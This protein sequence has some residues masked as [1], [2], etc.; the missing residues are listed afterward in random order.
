ME[1]SLE[2]DDEILSSAEE[3]KYIKK[4]ARK[5]KKLDDNIEVQSFVVKFKDW[6]KILKYYE[7]DEIRHQI[8]MKQMDILA[9]I[10]NGSIG[11]P[12]IKQAIILYDLYENAIK[13]GFLI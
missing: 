11:L 10:A 3:E 4:E 6:D 7:K 13:E 8:S 2:F 5:D 9:K 12:S 1:V